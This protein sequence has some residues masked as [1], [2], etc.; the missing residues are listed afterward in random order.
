MI[1]ES[2]GDELKFDRIRAATKIQVRKIF[3]KEFL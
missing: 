3:T 1:F 2:F